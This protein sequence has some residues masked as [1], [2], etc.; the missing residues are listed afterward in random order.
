[1]TRL[2]TSAQIKGFIVLIS[3]KKM[4]VEAYAYTY[5]LSLA[6]AE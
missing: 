6:K 4:R 3:G 1:L 2:R 5:I